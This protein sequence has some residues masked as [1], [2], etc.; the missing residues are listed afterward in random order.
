MNRDVAPMGFHLCDPVKTSPFESQPNFPLHHPRPSNRIT[1]ESQ[2]NYTRST[3]LATPKGWYNE[4]R[5]GPARAS[6]FAIGLKHLLPNHNRI[7]L[8][9]IRVF[10]TELQ[11]NYNWITIELYP[12]RN[13]HHPTKNPSHYSHLKSHS[14]SGLITKTPPSRPA[15]PSPQHPPSPRNLLQPKRK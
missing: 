1:T 3:I 8:S 12:Q 13:T 10:P 5:C 4:S 7:S 2:S 15:T 9:T 11:S 6:T 14:G